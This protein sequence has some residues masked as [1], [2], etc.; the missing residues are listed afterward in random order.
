MT[1]YVLKIGLNIFKKLVKDEFKNEL[2][3]QQVLETFTPV[4][5]TKKI[6]K[7]RADDVASLFFWRKS[8]MGT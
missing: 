2:T 5:V 7:Q 3:K 6:K 1:P 8:A 4:Y